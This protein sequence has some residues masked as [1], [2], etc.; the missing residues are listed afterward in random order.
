MRPLPIQT[1]SLA[2]R[3]FVP[4][5]APALH[6]LNGEA[7]TRFWLPSHVYS[8]LSHASTAVT[9]L[10]GC[11]SSPGDARHGPYVLG[12]ELRRTGELIGH[13][14]FS[15]LD[16]E[17]EISYAIA[18]GCRRR[19]HAIEALAGA[20]GWAADAFALTCLTAI[21]A[22]A[23]VASCRLLERT[24]FCHRGEESRLFQGTEQRVS[25]YVWSPA[26]SGAASA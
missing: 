22:C 20:C 13:V 19:G 15:P 7:S 2:L 10:I 5:D 1:T 11:Y 24:G 18:E 26:G 23:N 21:T 25:R 8:D 6:R 16:G 12:V 3:R 4:G 14:G 17:V 9:Y